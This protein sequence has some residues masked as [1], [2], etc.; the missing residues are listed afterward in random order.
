MFRLK[1]MIGLFAGA[2]M[3]T[4]GI[5]QASAT[6]LRIASGFGDNHSATRAL[7]EVFARKVEELTDGRYTVS[8]FPNSELGQATE[9]VNQAQ[10]GINFGVYVSSA[11]YN[12]QVPELGVTN[13]PFVF[14]DRE[15]AFKVFDGP[16]GDKFKPLFEKS[17]LVVLGYM[18]L[19]FRNVTNSVR[20]IA[21]PAD[22]KGLKIRLQ[23][24]P[25]H[26][27]TFRQLGANPVSID[28]SEMFAALSQG[29][30]DAQENPYSVINA[31]RLYDA[32]QKYMSDTG[33]FFDVIVFAGSKSMLDAMSA[34]DRQAILNAG[35]LA[36]EAQ[37]K[38]AKED[39]AADL[40]SILSHGVTFTRL[41]PEER[42]DFRK[43]TLPVYDLVRERLGAGLVDE[44]LADVDA[45]K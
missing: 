2:L 31:F 36:T 13:L 22:L 1:T 24:N 21:E 41:T 4:A 6:E 39:E 8:V 18:E 25:V 33:H 20:K 5:S 44:F 30:V 27:A 45:A 17:G 26:I 38:F 42:E 11:F 15:T 28:G 43:A 29:V 35:R 3:L 9:M 19:G 14:P 23:N 40:K 12:S 32:G 34:E 10:S 7:R 16:F 37:R